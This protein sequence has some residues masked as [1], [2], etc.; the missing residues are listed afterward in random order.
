MALWMLSSQ[1]CQLIHRKCW[2]LPKIIPR[3]AGGQQVSYFYSQPEE[4]LMTR[5]LI[6]L[7][8]FVFF[9]AAVICHASAETNRRNHALS[10]G[11]DRHDISSTVWPP[12]SLLLS[13]GSTN[14]NAA[15]G[16]LVNPY[17]DP[18]P[19]FWTPPKTI[20]ISVRLERDVGVEEDLLSDAL[21]H[22]LIREAAWIAQSGEEFQ[23]K[24]DLVRKLALMGER[25][26]TNDG[27]D[28]WI[29]WKL[30][31]DD[32]D[33][34]SVW[35]GKA[36][37][38]GCYGSQLPLIKSRSIIPLSCKDMVDLMMDSSKVPVYNTWSMGRKDCWVLDDHTKIVQNRVKPPI[39]SRQLVSTTL[40][41]A[42]PLDNDAWVI[43]SRAVRGF[44]EPEDA[45][46]TEILL[47]VNLVE[48]LGDNSCRLT[49]VNHVYTSGV[50]TMLA[51]SLGVKSA[52]KFVN[53]LRRLRGEGKI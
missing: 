35:T 20:K 17:A 28:E 3:G 50:P 13:N 19:I 8:L 38:S 36:Q 24:P 21:S 29:K 48:P 2:R 9:P 18:P 51:E 33:G 7:R 39:G 46:K 10:F 4:F 44:P 25:V 41:H 52:V 14:G 43:V 42:C 6:M 22:P 11:S 5:L 30:S 47:G 37:K 40:L 32:P 1:S 16:T 53:D 31:K 45:S 15:A 34:I 49:S 12:S 27:P 26:A 23:R